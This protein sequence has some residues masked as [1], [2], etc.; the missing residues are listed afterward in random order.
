[1]VKHLLSKQTSQLS[2]VHWVS[3]KQIYIRKDISSSCSDYE[4]M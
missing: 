2:T 1:M 4:I 3:V